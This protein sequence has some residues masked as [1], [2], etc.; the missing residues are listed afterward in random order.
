MLISSELRMTCCSHQDDP[1]WQLVSEAFRRDW[2]RFA[3]ISSG[4]SAH[5]HCP[6][7]NVTENFSDEPVIRTSNGP[8]TIEPV[9]FRNEKQEEAYRFGYAAY[10]HFCGGEEWNSET[11]A[12]LRQNWGDEED[13]QAHRL[14]IRHG[15]LFAKDQARHVR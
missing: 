9:A 15:W 4:E 6:P 7:N 13:W 14:A 5:R 8:D 10:R 11:E 12:I 3:D 1:A 2:K